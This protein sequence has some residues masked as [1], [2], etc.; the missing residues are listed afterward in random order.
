M[1]IF[2]LFLFVIVGVLFLPEAFIYT[3]VKRFIPISGNG[4]NAMDNF[5]MTVLLVKALMCAVVAGTVIT[6]FRTR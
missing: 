1:E 5:E 2:I 4:E 3:F 6:L